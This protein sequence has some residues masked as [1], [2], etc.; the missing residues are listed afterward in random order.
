[1]VNKGRKIQNSV[2]NIPILAG[3]QLTVHQ[4]H[5]LSEEKSKAEDFAI[6]KIDAAKLCM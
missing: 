4:M 3:K 6:T 5:R 1:M 2:S